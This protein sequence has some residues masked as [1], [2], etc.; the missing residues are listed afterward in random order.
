[1]NTERLNEIYNKFPKVNLEKV[2]LKSINEIL[3]YSSGVMTFGKNIDIEEK[4]IISLKRSLSVSIGDLEREMK[5]LKK[6]IIEVE[7]SMKELGINA[8]TI[9]KYKEAK[10]SLDYGEK[11]LKKGKQLQK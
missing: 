2:E 6:G 1:M 3:K 5:Q 4:E 9:Q 11:Q 8:N 10:N 7:K